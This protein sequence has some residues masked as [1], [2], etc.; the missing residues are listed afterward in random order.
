MCTT[1][2]FRKYK[3]LAFYY[4]RSYIR[5]KVIL[6]E[7]HLLTV[8]DDES[9]SHLMEGLLLLVRSLMMVMGVI[10]VVYKYLHLMSKKTHIRGTVL[11]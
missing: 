2:K 6:M 8:L 1:Q 11:S 5:W 7:K 10:L 4:A 3:C 9:E